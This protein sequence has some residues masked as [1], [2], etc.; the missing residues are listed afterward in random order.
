MLG[1]VL[2]ASRYGV[3]VVLAGLLIL[4]LLA[5]VALLKCRREDV[6]RIVEGLALWWRR[7]K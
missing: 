3:V 5:L 7:K 2:D 4:G 6:P 1:D